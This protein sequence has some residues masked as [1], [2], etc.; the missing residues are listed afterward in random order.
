MNQ[1]SQDVT[2]R[3]V[4]C[5]E[6]SNT[7]PAPLNF[8]AEIILCIVILFIQSRQHYHERC[9]IIAAVMRLILFIG[10][11][12]VFLSWLLWQQQ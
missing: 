8:K 1:Q 6:I 9:G 5:S 4:L 2:K 12:S 10:V 11:I 7:E 3:P